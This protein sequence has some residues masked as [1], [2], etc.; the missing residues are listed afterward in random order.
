MGGTE[1]DDT[2]HNMRPPA[3]G[4]D[5]VDQ[6]SKPT[7]YC[8]EASPPRET[9]KADNIAKTRVGWIIA[10]SALTELEAFT[11]DRRVNVRQARDIKVN[12][13]EQTPG[14][15]S[16]EKPTVELKD[17]SKLQLFDTPARLVA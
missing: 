13:W 14:E 3:V 12:S 1:F 8:L 6:M 7:A 17:I 9:P 11:L 2:I 16:V 4:E 5:Q 10:C 15:A